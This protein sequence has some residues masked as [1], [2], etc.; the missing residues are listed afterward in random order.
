MAGVGRFA[1]F[2]LVAAALALIVAYG[3]GARTAK[4]GLRTPVTVAAGP[5]N[6]DDFWALVDHSASWGEDADAQLVDLC[7]PLGRLTPSQII[8]FKV[9]SMRR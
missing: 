1:V 4:P 3:G 6:R 5:L 7:T 9:I 2:T 8:T